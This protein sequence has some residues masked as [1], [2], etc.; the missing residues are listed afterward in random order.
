MLYFHSYIIGDV[1]LIQSDAAV[2]RVPTDKE[3]IR[4]DQG[5]CVVLT[6]TG[7]KVLHCSSPT[8]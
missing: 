8:D 5:L 3:L 1:D 7:G 2:P 4:G 6:R